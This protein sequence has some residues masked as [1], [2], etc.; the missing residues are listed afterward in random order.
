MKKIFKSEMKIFVSD[1]EL[2][3]HV[4]YR[5]PGTHPAQLF[6]SHDYSEIAIIISGEAEHIADDQRKKISAGDILLIHPGTVHAYDHTGNME[7]VNLLYDHSRLSLPLLDSYDLPLLRHILPPIG[8]YRNSADAL[9]RLTAEELTSTLEAIQELEDE[10]K[11]R[12][13]G[14]QFHTLAMFMKIISQLARI[15][16]IQDTKQRICFQI[17]DAISYINRHFQQAVNVEK[18]AKT[19]NMS[20]RNFQRYFKNTTGCSP[21]GFLTRVR[22]RNAANLLI[23]SEESI[24]II[25]LNCGFYDSNYFCKKFKEHFG[26]SP[27]QFRLQHR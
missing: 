2:P 12:K 19:A 11:N 6:H 4:V 25:A 23:N 18:L 3:V 7:I 9:L 13:P 20:I 1:G 22:L 5:A 21:A 10:L 16:S 27:K 26:I 15:G 14:R 24:G 8:E 17:G